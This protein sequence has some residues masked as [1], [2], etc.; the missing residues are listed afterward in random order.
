MILLATDQL[1]ARTD[2]RRQSPARRLTAKIV[3]PEPI[4]FLAGIADWPSIDALLHDRS[5]AMIATQGIPAWQGFG[6]RVRGDGLLSFGSVSDV[7]R[8]V[9]TERLAS[10]DGFLWVDDSGTAWAVRPSFPG[11]DD[12]D[13]LAFA[14]SWNGIA[15]PLDP[16]ARRWALRNLAARMARASRPGRV[17]T[18]SER[19]CFAEWVRLVANCNLLT[20]Q[21]ESWTVSVLGTGPLSSPPSTCRWTTPTRTL[22]KFGR[23]SVRRRPSRLPNF[24]SAGWAG[25]HAWSASQ[26]P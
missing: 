13:Q 17:W 19:I 25:I 7:G 26:L 8:R 6:G 24:G 16:G 10:L 14:L 20:W 23:R 12:V 22:T 21:C 1:R 9:L 4:D 2:R 3:G 18:R 11:P 15:W 5:L